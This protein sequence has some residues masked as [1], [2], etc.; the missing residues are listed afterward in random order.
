MALPTLLSALVLIVTLVGVGAPAALQQKA[1]GG[2]APKA[3]IL[4]K[5]HCQVCHVDGSSPVS[6]LNFADGEWT[7]GSRLNEVVTV[8]QDGVPET[9]MTAF[10]DI[11]TKQEIRALAEY[12]RGFDKSLKSEKPK[13]IVKPRG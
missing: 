5:K 9:A 12:V 8:I 1:A 2:A 7:H 3:E 11:L 10:K 4:Y 6:E 13:K